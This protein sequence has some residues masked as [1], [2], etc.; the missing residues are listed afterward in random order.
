MERSRKR[1]Y[2]SKLLPVLAAALPSAVILGVLWRADRLLFEAALS[3]AALALAALLLR[4]VARRERREEELKRPSL[5]LEAIL[6]LSP[7]G[8]WVK[9]EESRYLIVN[10]AI[11]RQIDNLSKAEVIGRRT[12][13]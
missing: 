9:D 8:L 4:E 3:L 7:A 6:E 13:D 12:V 5:L 1:W 2:R 11:L 10:P